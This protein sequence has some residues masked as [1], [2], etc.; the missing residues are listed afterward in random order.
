MATLK[1]LEDAFSS[2]SNSIISLGDSL[3]SQMMSLNNTNNDILNSNKEQIETLKS[4]LKIEEDRQKPKPDTSFV[5]PLEDPAK[6]NEKSGAM[7]AGEEWGSLLTSINGLLAGA[8][9]LGLAF[10]GLRGWEVKIIDFVKDG[11][12]NLKNSIISG[13]KSIKT[14]VLLAFGLDDTG[15]VIPNSQLDDLLK[16]PIMQKITSGISKILGPLKSMG[17]FLTGFL[18]GTGAAGESSKAVKFL[19]EVGTNIGAFANVVGNILKPIGF[20]FSAYDGVMAFMNKEGDI[21][22]KTVAGIGGF[23]G[24]FIGAPIDLLKNIISWGISKLGFENAAEILE[25]FSFEELINKVINGFYN[26]IRDAVEWVGTIFTDPTT[27]LTDS[28]N[29]MYGE[30]GLI[31]MLLAPISM[32]VDWITKKLGWRDEDAPPLDIYGIVAGFVSSSLSWAEEKLTDLSDTLSK[33]FDVIADYVSTIPDR[34]KFAAEGMFIDVAARVEK[35]FVMFGDWIASIP[36]RIKLLALSA[37]NSALSGLPEWA[38][39]V[40]ADDIAAAQA[41]VNQKSENTN[42]KLQEI[43]S[44]TQEKRLDL[45]ERMAASGIYNSVS[46]ATEETWKLRDDMKISSQAAEKLELTQQQNRILEEREAE[47]SRARSGEDSPFFNHVGNTNTDARTFV[48]GATNT[49]IIM[50][51]SASDLD[52][53]LPRM[54]R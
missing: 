27:A 28:W 30:N 39:I 35:G 7:K 10:A 38:Q 40:T 29:A 43:D 6:A 41:A 9:A 20:L 44:R 31:D 11:L 36:G 23:I 24:D 22:D 4:I 52:Y 51:R 37:I 32:A 3:N 18:S 54:V 34:I 15:K 2:M 26:M 17:D 5:P 46:A 16:T 1:D 53:G 14:G 8:A 47:I 19:G 49:T 50:P 42:K 25:S 13:I 33:G 12:G 21:L 48:G 45:E